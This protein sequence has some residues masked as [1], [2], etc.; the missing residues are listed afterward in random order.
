MR[1]NV[2]W[3][4]WSPTGKH[5][6]TMRHNTEQGAIDEA[7]RLARLNPCQEFY[8][9]SAEHLRVTDNMLRVRLEHPMPF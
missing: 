5:P 4:V 9:L 3:I 7:E 1:T 2:F 8:C 6:P